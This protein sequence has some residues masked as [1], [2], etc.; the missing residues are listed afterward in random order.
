M[1]TLLQWIAR[2]AGLAGALVFV[3][4]LGTRAA[5]LYSIGGVQAGTLLGLSAA[6]MA[7]AGLCYL[8][9]LVEFRRA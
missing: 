6:T 4:A 9:L 1:E 5:G 3:I 8:A 7:L 2:L